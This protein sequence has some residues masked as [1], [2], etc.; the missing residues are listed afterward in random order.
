[1][2]W[3]NV[4]LSTLRAPEYVSSEPTARATWWN[5]LA[6][7]AEQENGGRIVG[8][9]KWKDRQ[10][11]QTCGVMVAEVD[12]APELLKWD[13]DDLVVWNYPVEKEEEIRV[14]REAG[15]VGGERS[16]EARSNHPAK[17]TKELNGSSASSNASSSASTEGEVEGE[18]NKKGKETRGR[19]GVDFDS[20]PE[21]LGVEAFRGAWLVYVAYRKRM[22]FKPLDT[23]T[24]ALRWK[25]MAEWGAEPAVAQI[26]EAMRQGWQGIFAPKGQQNK[27][28]KPPSRPA[29]AYDA[30]SLI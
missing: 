21:Q 25:T 2:N 29:V 8:A 18:E 13:G 3:L 19:V 20:L 11:Q 14:K 17:H 9:R 22:K 30:P 23:E 4:R 16:G 12:S 15:K 28:P 10:W 1:M 27:L 24:T 6:Y 5:A 26:E 7:C